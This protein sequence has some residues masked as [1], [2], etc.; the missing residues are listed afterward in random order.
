MKWAKKERDLDS[1]LPPVVTL[2]KSRPVLLAHPTT[3]GKTEILAF[4]Y[5]LLIS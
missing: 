1:K 2:Q 3:P 4:V 5:N